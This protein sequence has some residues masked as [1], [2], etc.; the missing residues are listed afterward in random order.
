MEFISEMPATETRAGLR[1]YYKENPLSGW[2]YLDCIEWL[3]DPSLPLIYDTRKME[4]FEREGLIP[5]NLEKQQNSELDGYAMFGTYYRTDA[6]MSYIYYRF[7]SDVLWFV[8]KLKW[9]GSA[10]IMTAM[11]WG[12]AYVPMGE[13]PTW[14]HLGRKRPCS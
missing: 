10:L 1:Y 6:G 9:I 14:Q 5:W 8:N 2:R 3:G 11:V 13:Y 12:L 4:L 7:Q